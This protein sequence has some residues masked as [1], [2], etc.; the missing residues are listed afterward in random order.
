MNLNT[1]H[2]GDAVEYL[3]SLPDGCVNCVVT[4]PPYYGLRDYGVEGQIGLDGT[5]PEYLDKLR[6]L[7]AEVKRVLRDDGTCWVNMGDSYNGYKANTND[8]SFTGKVGNPKIESGHGLQ[9]KRL[10]AKNLLGVPWRL[11]FVMQDDGW[12]L[13][14]DCIWH[15][16]AVMPESVTDRPSKSHEYVFLFAKSPRYWYD[17]D[18]VREPLAESTIPRSKRAVSAT[19]KYVNGPAGQHAHSMA[20]PRAN[21]EG[22]PINELG[23]NLRTV[24]TIAAEPTS[25]A[26]FA[27]FP[28]K[29]AQR[30][31]LAGCP[32]EVCAKCGAPYVREAHEEF[33]PQEDVSPERV[34]FRGKMADENQWKGFPRGTKHTTTKGFSPTCTCTAGTRPGV[35]LDPFMGSGT[36]ALVAR[37]E[38]RNFLGCDL[39]PEYVKIAEKRLA[40]PYTPRLFYDDE[41]EAV[42]R[43]E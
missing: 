33:I 7:F 43:N 5:L 15:K 6:A 36:T 41:I 38:G 10:P 20:Q 16:P 32:R 34:A 42:E 30:C 3:R 37:A 13:R 28:R 12:I 21:G 14:S 39:N 22:Y 8:T 29:L 35:V 27:T 18:A 23:R 4:S 2:C 11:A 25:Y 17:A 40:I 9:D 1:I 31:I 19:H 26:H 24:W